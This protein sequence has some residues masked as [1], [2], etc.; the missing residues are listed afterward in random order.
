MDRSLASSRQVLTIIQNMKASTAKKTPIII[1]VL[2]EK[3]I[4][5]A[6]TCGSM[7]PP[8]L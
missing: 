1:R 8:E 3:A 2:A 4:F 5:E 6:T 7:I